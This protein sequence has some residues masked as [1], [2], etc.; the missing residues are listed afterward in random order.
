MTK[1]NQAELD[2][3]IES[4]RKWFPKGSTVYTIL[5]KVSASGMSRQISIVALLVD[6]EKVVDLHPN[7][8]VAAVTG[9]RLNSKGSHD[10][11][12]V[13]GCGMDMGFHVVSRLAEVL[14]GDYRT[15]SHRW[16]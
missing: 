7:Y 1:I 9:F 10:A 8:A 12:I 11:L 2:R 4:L 5:R 6:G 14:Y 15:L 16:L 13:G 3:Q